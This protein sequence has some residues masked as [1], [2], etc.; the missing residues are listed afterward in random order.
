MK[1][2]KTK[3]EARIGGSGF[4]AGLGDKEK[5]ITSLPRNP[6][7]WMDGYWQFYVESWGGWMKLREGTKSTSRPMTFNEGVCHINYMYGR[8]NDGGKRIDD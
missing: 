7:K 1:N 4:N 6:Y 5:I 8:P 3:N 2:Q